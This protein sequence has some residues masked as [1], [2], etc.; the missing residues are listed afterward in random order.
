M[1]SYLV[2]LFLS[3][4]MVVDYGASFRTHQEIACSSDKSLLIMTCLPNSMVA[5]FVQFF[6]DIWV[7]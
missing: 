6:P 4:F 1:T 7:I 3:I 5:W 2:Y